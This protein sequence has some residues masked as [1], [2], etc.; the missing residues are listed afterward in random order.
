MSITALAKALTIYDLLLEALV[1]DMGGDV[2]DS[3]Q[4]EEEKRDGDGDRVMS[5]VAVAVEL[6]SP[7]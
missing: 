3:G 6:H 4:E 1:V 2:E 5:R 7:Y